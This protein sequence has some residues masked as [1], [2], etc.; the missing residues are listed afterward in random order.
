M[1]S[2]SEFESL[3]QDLDRV[4]HS[5]TE[6]DSVLERVSCP[7]WEHRDPIVSALWHSIIAAENLL[8][9]K[10]RLRDPLNPRAR[11]ITE[12]ALEQCQ[13]LAEADEA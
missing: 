3:W 13:E 10:G 9:L 12:V 7:P 6:S 2:P 11:Q 4:L 1:S 5:A 8:L